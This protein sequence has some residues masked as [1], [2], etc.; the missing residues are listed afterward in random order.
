MP[1]AY[2]QKDRRVNPRVDAIIPIVFRVL[3]DPKEIRS[4]RDRGKKEVH[5]PTLNVS[6]GGMY[7][8]AD[9][10]LEQGNILSFDIPIPGV[11]KKLNAMAEVVWS[12]EM[13]GGIRFL[14]MKNN[15]L[16]T[17][18]AYIDKASLSD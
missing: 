16:K 4:I 13:G 8:V 10:T 2:L 3:D 14:A 1:E 15:D 5:H 6:L 9:Q 17:F 7:I 11:V 18:K 12:N